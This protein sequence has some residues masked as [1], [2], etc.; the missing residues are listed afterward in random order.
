MGIECG[1]AAFI[2]EPPIIE[3]NG[4]IARIVYRRLDNDR[5]MSVRT[6]KRIIERGTRALDRHA[7]GEDHIIVDD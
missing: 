5:V 4:S 6:L 1:F 7:T 2:D 3:I